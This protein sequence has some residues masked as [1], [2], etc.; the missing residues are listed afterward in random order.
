[1]TMTV[2]VTTHAH[3][4]TRAGCLRRIM[5]LWIHMGFDARIASVL[6]DLIE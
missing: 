2:T 5:D 1:M 4:R 6:R 3:T